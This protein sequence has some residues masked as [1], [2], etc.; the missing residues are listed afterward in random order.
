MLGMVAAFALFLFIAIIDPQLDAD[1]LILLPCVGFGLALFM[2]LHTRLS[3]TMF[4]VND[5]QVAWIPLAIGGLLTLAGAAGLMLGQI[6][7][8]A[9]SSINFY[10]TVCCWL[11]SVWGI[12]PLLF[13]IL[14]S[15][16]FI[17]MT[18]SNFYVMLL[19]L[20]FGKYTPLW[21]IE[22]HLAWWPLWA[23]GCVFLI[24]E[25]PRQTAV[26]RRL[27]TKESGTGWMKTKVPDLTGPTHP[28]WP[29]RLA[30]SLI[31]LYWSSIIITIIVREN[32]MLFH[33]DSNDYSALP[34]LGLLFI[35]FFLF[36]NVWRQNR[37]S[38]MSGLRA[39][40]VMLVEMTGVGYAFRDKLGVAR[41]EKVRCG[42]CGNWRMAWHEACPHCGGGQPKQE[43]LSTAQT[44]QKPGLRSLMFPR[45]D[46][47]AMFFR[48]MAPIYVLGFIILFHWRH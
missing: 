48:V 6:F 31:F 15:W 36:G 18:A 5:R 14:L 22:I 26:L 1:C 8:L 28:T 9:D 11:S 34:F 32:A 17:L 21:L 24:W 44:I 25:A 41:G 46:R 29:T 47:D 40:G 33:F 23:V 35:L 2:G 10:D 3:H 37:A 16:R 13:I 27:D 43:T 45:H 19:P 4:P 12:P 7:A 38:G 42:L 30:D 20:F 39:T